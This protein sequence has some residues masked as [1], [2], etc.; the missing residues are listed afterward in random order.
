MSGEPNHL[1]NNEYEA[2][3][4]VFRKIFKIHLDLRFF[5]GSCGIFF[6]IHNVMSLCYFLLAIFSLQLERSP[7]NVKILGDL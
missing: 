7:T 6:T 5:L 3:L 4:V 2:V 1:E